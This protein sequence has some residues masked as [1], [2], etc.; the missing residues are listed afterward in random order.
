MPA[1]T[2]RNI[3]G[4]DVSSDWIDAACWKASEN[5]L[6]ERRFDNTPAGHRQLAQWLREKKK[7]P[8]RVAVEATGIY[9]LDLMLALHDCGGVDV[10]SVHPRAL[11]DY[12]RARMQRSKTDQIDA[13]LICDFCRRMPF[14]QWQPPAEEVFEL[15]T[16]ARRLQVLIDEGVREKNRLHAAEESAHGSSSYVINDIEVNLRHLKRRAKRLEK[17]AV[18]LV[19]KHTRLQESFAHLKSVRGIGDRS[20]IKLLGEVAMMPEDLSVREWVAYAGL[21]VRHH[22]SGSSVRRP[23]HISKEGNKRIR[24]ALYMPAQVAIQH[25]PNVG[26]FYDKLIGRGKAPMVAVVAV[27]RKLLHSIYGMLKHD[28][29]FEGDKF[30]RIPKKVPATA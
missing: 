29:D 24:Q 30:Y 17:Q 4:C 12:R 13:K 10:M 16:L 27:M 2:N 7:R 15:R 9:S 25:E 19:R 23:G 14:E 6:H 21:D 5:R 3:A 11:R 28:V 26:A 22:E 20:A 18:R 1:P 8:V